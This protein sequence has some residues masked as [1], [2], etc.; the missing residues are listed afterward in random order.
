MGERRV[1]KR[2][3]P[4]PDDPAQSERFVET[5]KQA[6]AHVGSNTFIRAF[7][8]IVKRRETKKKR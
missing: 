7:K 2:P 8:A 1:S 5:A 4:P 3:K 6:E